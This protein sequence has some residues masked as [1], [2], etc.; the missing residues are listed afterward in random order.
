MPRRIVPNPRSW[1]PAAATSGA[2]AHRRSMKVPKRVKRA[3]FDPSP[4]AFARECVKERI[5]EPH[6]KTVEHPSQQEKPTCFQ[7]SLPKEFRPRCRKITGKG[8]F[9]RN[10][11]PSR[12]KKASLPGPQEPDHRK[13][14]P[15]MP[16][17]LAALATYGMISAA[18][19]GK[20]AA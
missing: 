10:G 9:S 13:L 16:H 3:V 1:A 17:S 14:L 6:S 5:S 19:K 12:R 7:E 8:A 11:Q 2:I 20:N 4:A 15:A 18:A